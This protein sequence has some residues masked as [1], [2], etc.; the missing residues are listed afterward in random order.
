M[1][2]TGLQIHLLVSFDVLIGLLPLGGH[3]E[4]RIYFDE[5]GNYTTKHSGSPSVTEVPPSEI[6]K[7]ELRL[8]QR[9]TEKR[10]F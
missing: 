3:S 6:L 1:L 5:I 4:F 9:N 7:G 2:N 10:D 8:R